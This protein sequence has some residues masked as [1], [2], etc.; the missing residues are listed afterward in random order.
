[1]QRFVNARPSISHLAGGDLRYLASGDT[2]AQSSAGRLHRAK[3]FFGVS[4]TQRK[5]EPM[6]MPRKIR[7]QTDPAGRCMSAER[8]YARCLRARP[9]RM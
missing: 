2:M 6:S 3:K 5:K 4:P 8:R 9:A 7:R 1:M